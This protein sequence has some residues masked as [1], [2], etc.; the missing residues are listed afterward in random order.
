VQPSIQGLSDATTTTWIGL[1]LMVAT[2]FLMN[3]TGALVEILMLRIST[4]IS[5]N[6]SQA[7]ASGSQG[8]NKQVSNSRPANPK[9]SD[10]PQPTGDLPDATPHAGPCLPNQSRNQPPRAR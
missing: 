7:G 9:V 1:M 8:A 4:C 2:I 3:K 5:A 10:V 6:Q